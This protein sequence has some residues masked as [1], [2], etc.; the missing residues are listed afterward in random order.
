MD[1]TVI[2]KVISSSLGN[3]YSSTSQQSIIQS[4]S[5]LECSSIIS[6]PNRSRTLN[7]S[8]P[9]NY[10]IAVNFTNATIDGNPD[11]LERTRVITKCSANGDVAIDAIYDI[12]DAKHDDQSASRRNKCIST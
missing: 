7:L 9:L 6:S 2:I 8:K 4:Q 3:Y 5:C 12:N 10:I 1:V 11:G